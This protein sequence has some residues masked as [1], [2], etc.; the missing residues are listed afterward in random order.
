VTLKRNN[1]LNIRNG[2]LGE[3]FTGTMAMVYKYTYET[4]VSAF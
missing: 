4:M 3:L 2:V 1:L